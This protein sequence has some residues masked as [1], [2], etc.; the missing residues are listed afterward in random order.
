[1]LGPYTSGETG[2]PVTL[3]F[4]D[5]PVD[6]SGLTVKM[7]M[8]KANGTEITFAGTVAWVDDT[9]GRC[10]I[11]FAASDLTLDP[12]VDWEVRVGQVWA[13]D[14]TEIVATLRLVIPIDSPV[15]SVPTFV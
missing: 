14:G 13:G 4:D 8:E 11:E 5:D 7:T 15:G 2:R 1:M 9:I 3:D 6:L 12:G 10:Q